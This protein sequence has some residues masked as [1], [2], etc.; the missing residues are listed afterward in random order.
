MT[1]IFLNAFVCIKNCCQPQQDFTV[2]FDTGSSVLWVP[3][4]HC[5]SHLCEYRHKFDQAKS[6]TYLALDKKVLYQNL[7]QQTN[8]FKF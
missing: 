6:S 3:G 4:A 1:I 7:T 5:K 8:D 2:V